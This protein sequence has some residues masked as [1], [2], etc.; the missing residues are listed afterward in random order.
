MGIQI[1]WTGRIIIQFMSDIE[2][3]ELPRMDSRIAEFSRGPPHK[4]YMEKQ[5]NKIEELSQ[6]S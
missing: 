2:L 6:Y 1:T 4:E 3:H 5:I